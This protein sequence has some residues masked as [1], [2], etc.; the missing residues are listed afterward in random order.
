MVLSKSESRQAGKGGRGGRAAGQG[1]RGGGGGRGTH[2]L[3]R[4]AQPSAPPRQG[5]SHQST[6]PLC[7]QGSRS[8]SRSRSEGTHLPPAH[9]RT[10]CRPSGLIAL[11]V[12]EPAPQSGDTF[13]P[14]ENEGRVPGDKANSGMSRQL[15]WQG[16][17]SLGHHTMTFFYPSKANFT[18]EFSLSQTLNSAPL[19]TPGFN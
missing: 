1:L 8:R 3:P 14:K 15:P 9:L 10:G 6:R 13:F 18:P 19:Q 5:R 11:C 4:H 12:E 2:S 16:R 17:R 7:P